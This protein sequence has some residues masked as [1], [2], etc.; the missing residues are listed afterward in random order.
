MTA[1]L[2]VL[3]LA[4]WQCPYAASPAEALARLDSTAAL[5]RA[6]GADLLV[7][8]E[9]SLTGYSIGAARVQALAEPPDGLLAQAVGRIAQRHGLA[10]VFGYA[11]S[12]GS[13]RPFNAVQ[14]VDPD[15]VALAHYRK[16]HRF[17]DMDRQQFSPG[18]RA[19]AVFEWRGWRLGLLVCYDVEFPETVRLLAL[20][21]AEAVLVPTANMRA[22]DEV[23]H[24]LVPAR[25]CENRLYV[26]YANACGEEPGLV[27]GGLSTLAGPEGGMLVQ[28]GR[29]ELLLLGRLE[30]GA[31]K[32][33]QAGSQLPYR[34]TDLYGGLIG[35]PAP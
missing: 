29:D 32:A 21:G 13:E 20:Q 18:D 10:V 15:G 14:A 16:T 9:M 24:L 1:P 28:A 22:F 2:D 17:G 25:A 33:A 7:C 5:A 26:A 27:Y 6:Q 23:P 4:L 3:T 11:E 34:R 30:R 12:N 31:L 19:P 35:K 8:P